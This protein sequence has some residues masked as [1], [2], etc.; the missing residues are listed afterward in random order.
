M[1]KKWEIN[2]MKIQESATSI[3]SYRSRNP[4]NTVTS[5]L[6]YKTIN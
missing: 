1:N 6:K 2:S 4:G 3:Q 5:D